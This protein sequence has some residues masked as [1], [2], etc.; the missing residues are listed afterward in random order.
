MRLLRGLGKLLTP[1]LQ[2]QVLGRGYN[3][4]EHKQDGL[5]P[6]R[7][8]VVIEN[9]QEVDYFTEKLLDCMLC[10]TLPIYWGAP[11]IE[12]YFDVAGMIICNS[13]IDLQQAVV[14][15]GG[16][17]AM[18]TASQCLAMELN[19]KVELHLSQLPPRLVEEIIKQGSQC[20]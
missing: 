8:S 4:F 1:P 19:R 18:P 6:Y 2:V 12:K 17:Q 16:S 11:N 14:R 3:P 10:G 13:L 5:L 7:Y 15:V 9:V 20:Q